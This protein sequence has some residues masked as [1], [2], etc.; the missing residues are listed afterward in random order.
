MP[1]RGYLHRTGKEY[2]QYSKD[3]Y[4]AKNT[5]SVPKREKITYSD[6]R[7]D[8]AKRRKRVGVKT[9]R[10]KQSDIFKNLRTPTHP[11]LKPEVLENKESNEC[12]EHHKLLH[13]RRK[14]LRL[15][16]FHN[17]RDT[18]CTSDNV[19]VIKQSYTTTSRELKNNAYATPTGFSSHKKF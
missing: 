10:A 9:G 7:T 3:M 1:S 15:N 18:T 16:N 4:S 19:E 11:H 5:D 8:S 2:G 6:K 14:K 17:M 13:S 12:S